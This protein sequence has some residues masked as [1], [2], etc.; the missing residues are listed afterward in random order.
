MSAPRIRK[1][2]KNVTFLSCR[3]PGRNPIVLF[4]E[5]DPFTVHPSTRIYLADLEYARTLQNP[6]KGYED[7]DEPTRRNM[8]GQMVPTSPTKVARTVPSMVSPIASIPLKVPASDVHVKVIWQSETSVIVVMTYPVGS[9][10]LYVGPEDHHWRF[11][12]RLLVPRV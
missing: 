9:T 10:N 5:S 6:Y 1:R 11:L 8:L 4:L 3:Q 2:L 12:G 7:D